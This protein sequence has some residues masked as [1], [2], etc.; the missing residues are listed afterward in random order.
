[1]NS[2][3][4]ILPAALA[5]LLFVPLAMRLGVGPAQASKPGEPPVAAPVEETC[6]Q[7]CTAI[8]SCGRDAAAA[9]GLAPDPDPKL[10][11]P[12]DVPKARAACLN[13]CI[14]TAREEPEY[15]ET[16][17]ACSECVKTFDCRDVRDCLATC[18]PDP[19]ILAGR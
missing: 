8:A 14:E 12:L 15:A 7:A 5:G 17:G 6:D 3:R 11:P 16:V 19:A 10:A 1:M 13:P 2:K 9:M 4:W 18:R